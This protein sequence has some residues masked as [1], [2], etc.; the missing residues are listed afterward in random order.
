[1][2]KGEYTRTSPRAVIESVFIF[3]MADGSH[4]ML[5]ALL[6]R[7]VKLETESFKSLIVFPNK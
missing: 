7:I 3:Q 6:I 1:M 2:S 5:V 4:D